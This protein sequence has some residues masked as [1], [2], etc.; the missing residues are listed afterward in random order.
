MDPNNFERQLNEMLDR[1]EP[2]DR[3]RTFIANSG[4]RLNEQDDLVMNQY[5][6]ARVGGQHKDVN[7]M[8]REEMPKNQPDTQTP[9]GF[10]AAMLGAGN[11]LTMG[12]L[13]Y[14]GALV[15]TLGGTGGRENLWNSNKSVMDLLRVN[16]NANNTQLS[17][18]EAAHPGA[19]HAGEIAGIGA[20]FALP[21]AGAFRGARLA[22]ETPSVQALGRYAAP[23][24]EREGVE[25]ATGRGAEMTA[26]EALRRTGMG[27]DEFMA[28]IM[29]RPYIQNV[30]DQDVARMGM[31]GMS[32]EQA[33]L[34]RARDIAR[35]DMRGYAG[36]PRP[37]TYSPDQ[38]RAMEASAS[39]SQAAEAAEFE[40]QWLARNR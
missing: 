19:Y 13:P 33:Q 10:G 27:Q 24:L 20:G 7:A 31:G 34:A 12:A 11:A 5:E 35:S 16:A 17:N 21:V 8:T 1:N 18:T 26:E 2:A 6:Q 37:S 15:D 32:R 30:I 4:Y 3:I 39:R 14:A 22:A 40:R 38:V 23:V 36:S 28:D 25:A 9:D 29:R